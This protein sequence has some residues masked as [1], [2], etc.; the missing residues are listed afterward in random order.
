[1]FESVTIVILMASFAGM[2]TILIRKV[3]VLKTLEI[4]KEPETSLFLRTKDKIAKTFFVGFHKVFISNFWNIFLQR[5]LSKIKILSLK[6]ETKCSRSLEK[7]RE[8]IKKSKEDEKY[9][10]KIVEAS[11]KKKK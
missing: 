2:A 9:W 5:T 3:P 1:M 11:S 4:P 7:M 10:G 6:I 8:N